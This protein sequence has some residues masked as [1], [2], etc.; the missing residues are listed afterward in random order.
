MTSLEEIEAAVAQLSPADLKKLRAWLDELDERLFD[1]KIE[2]D[3][4]A[5]KLDKLAAK[6]IAEDDAGTTSEL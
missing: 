3:A 2:R 5:G 6:A 1:E 4:K